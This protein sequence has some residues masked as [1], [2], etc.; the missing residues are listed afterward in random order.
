MNRKDEL[1]AERKELVAQREA[2]TQKLKENYDELDLIE[3]EKLEK[4]RDNWWLRP[5]RSKQL[6]IWCWGSGVTASEASKILDK[7]FNELKPEGI[8]MFMRSGWKL[9]GDE[10]DDD[11][12]VDFPV[13]TIGFERESTADL[14]GVWKAI[15]R[16]ASVWTQIGSRDFYVS[17]MDWSCSANGVW[18]WYPFVGGG[19]GEVRCLRYGSET[20]EAEFKGKHPEDALEWIRKNV[21][22]ESSKRDEREEYDWQ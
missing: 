12:S 5:E 9:N 20:V 2:I 16:H 4:I 13:I 17:I 1:E 21:W 14:T 18:S 6:G 11:F 19:G 8:R 3:L 10:W 22:Y 7:F 15:I